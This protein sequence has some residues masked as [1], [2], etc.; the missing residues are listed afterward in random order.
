MSRKMSHI[1]V[2]VDA[3][4]AGL[5]VAQQP[6]GWFVDG[7]VG[8][9]GHAHAILSAAP[10]AHLLGLD[11]DPVALAL[12]RERLAPFVERAT[13]VHGSYVDLPQHVTAWRGAAR[14]V[15]GIL[16][17]LG[18]SSMQVEDAARGFAFRHDG[19][20][21]MRF[22]PTGGGTTAAD[23]VNDYEA[24]HLAD[25]LYRYGEERNSRRIARAIVAA[26]PLHST[27]QL[28]DVVAAAQR[29]PRQQI[30]PAT[31]TFQA[32]RIA[33]NSELDVIAQVLPLAINA[34][35][36]GGRLAVIA[37]H[38]LEDRI[39]KERFRHEAAD[40]ICPPRQP[41]CTCEHVA[42]VRL[43]T[44]KPVQADEAEVAANPRSRS[45]KLRVVERLD[46]EV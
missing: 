44:R 20:L 22:D 24:D 4:L 3:V 28:A 41:V 11:R 21:D 7:T 14:P 2:L 18:L 5:N 12:A 16:L 8:A 30:H 35:G 17:D 46:T 36:P 27:R 45:A 25:V 9:G 34:L 26:R 40:C 13:L 32:L 29:G 6:G 1:P 38:S 42:R 33:V 23:I 31:R 19:P 10:Q 15:D 39:V 37:F 43:V